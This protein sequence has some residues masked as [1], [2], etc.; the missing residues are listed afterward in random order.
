MKPCKPKPEWD[1]KLKVSWFSFLLLLLLFTSWKRSRERESKDRKGALNYII[2]LESGVNHHSFTGTYS[3]DAHRCEQ[4]LMSICDSQ[5]RDTL[6][7][8]CLNALQSLFL[9]VGIGPM[10]AGK[11][12]WSCKLHSFN[13][14]LDHQLSSR[15][16]LAKGSSIV[17]LV[18]ENISFCPRALGMTFILYVG[19]TM[20]LNTGPLQHKVIHG[21][22]DVSWR[23]L[24]NQTVSISAWGE[25]ITSS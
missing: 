4:P 19:E 6:R 18:L 23:S 24:L 21:I 7:W 17:L 11:P 8:S 9:I 20:L 5:A 1:F 16:T 14:H 15:C 12:W 22:P 10:H 3:R 2:F 13:L 25:V